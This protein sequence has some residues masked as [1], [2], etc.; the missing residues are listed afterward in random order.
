MNVIGGVF[1]LVATAILGTLCLIAPAV[2]AVLEAVRASDW[3]GLVLNGRQ[4]VLVLRGIGISLAAAVFALGP[5]AGLA[6]VMVH[7]GRLAAVARWLGLTILLTPPY[8]Y[9]YA[10]SLPLLPEGIAVAP[11][12]ASRGVAIAATYVRAIVCLGCWTAPLAGIVLAT[13]WWL[14]GFAGY[15]LALTD[16]T[17][18][19]ALRRGALAAMTPWILL[20]ASLVGVITLTEYS[21]CHLCL[22]PVWNTELLG[23]A[24]NATLPGRL[25]QRSWPLLAIVGLVLALWLWARRLRGDFL[26]SIAA[27]VFDAQQA[28]GARPV[29]GRWAAPVGVA[30]LLLIASPILVLVFWLRDYRA[31]FRTWLEFATDWGDGLLCAAGTV[32]VAGV[33]ALG[34]DFV[35]ALDSR[36][37]PRPIA[38]FGRGFALLVLLLSAFSAA[39]PPA[40]I[41]DAYLATYLTHAPALADHWSIVSLAGAA[42]YAL[43]AIIATRLAGRT[44]ADGLKE[45]AALDRAGP[46][47]AYFRVRLPQLAPAL[48]GS[49]LVVGV[50][51]L[52]EVAAAQLVTP[53]GLHNLAVTILNQIH[54]GRRDETIAMV[55]Q[56]FAAIG[57]L[58]LALEWLG[59]RRRIHAHRK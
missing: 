45:I 56:L 37:L 11:V 34:V 15:R 14:A 7:G 36:G 33:L 19:Q 2:V 58:M 23:D 38:V 6:A 5:G 16:A 20:A 29:R 18:W 22:V 8:V 43:I 21:V 32:V 57:L 30:A 48:V 51:A 41:G 27:H 26:T 59:G 9:A 10:W 44:R 42:R 55:L 24:Q 46:F 28:A 49:L 17:P 39:A 52:T 53:P 54:F 35:L 50:L 47:V 31:L 40:L 3:S 12:L 25:L 4:W 1:L 13:G